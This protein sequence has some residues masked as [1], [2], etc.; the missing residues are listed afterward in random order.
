MR[1]PHAQG[2]TG[3]KLLDIIPARAFPACAGINRSTGIRP[4]RGL[5]VPRMRRDQP[6]ASPW[7][8]RRRPRSP[9]AQGSTDGD[10][11]DWPVCAAF[12]AC[13]GIN[14]RNCLPPTHHLRVPRM[15]RDQPPSGSGPVG[16]EP[17]SPHAQGSTARRSLPPCPRPAFPACAGINRVVAIGCLQ[18]QSVPRMRRDQPFILCG[19]AGIRRR[20]P[21]AQ[22]S[23]VG[24]SRKAFRFS[25]FPACAGINRTPPGWIP[26]F[27]CVPRMR[28]DQPRLYLVAKMHLQRSP[29]AQG[30]TVKNDLKDATTIAFPACA[31]INRMQTGPGCQKPTERCYS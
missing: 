5:S 17:R 19:L 24:P 13:A 16:L 18:R 26:S 7:R 12:P 28:R 9:H 30:S 29:H 23:T 2:S 21:H 1:S 31:G 27:S 11:G 10:L 15:R 3:A 22:G 8:Q 4:R 25:A 14:L 6:S 20:S